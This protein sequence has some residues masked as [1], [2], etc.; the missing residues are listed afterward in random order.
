MML[1][2]R[3]LRAILILSMKAHVGQVTLKENFKLWH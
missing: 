1:A 3:I 2:G